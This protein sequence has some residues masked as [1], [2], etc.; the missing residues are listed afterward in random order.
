MRST[1]QPCKALPLYQRLIH[2]IK[3]ARLEQGLKSEYVARKIGVSRTTYSKI[4]TGRQALTVQRLVA[5]MVV[6]DMAWEELAAS[7]QEPGD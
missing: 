7:R 1:I 5:I 6:L 3:A 4:E 2:N